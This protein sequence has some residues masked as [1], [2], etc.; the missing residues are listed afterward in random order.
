[1]LKIKFE[2]GQGLGNQLWNYC[3]IRSIANKLSQ[4]FC[5]DGYENFHGKNFL[6]IDLGEPAV[7]LEFTLFN[8]RIYYDIDLEYFSSGYDERVLNIAENMCLKGLFQDERYFY[9]NHSI[10]N[11]YLKY[12]GNEYISDRNICVLNIR[13]GEYK[14]YKNFNL[15]K[16]YWLNA[17]QH[18][19]D[20]HGVSRFK[21]VTDDKLY[22]N[23]LFNSFEIISDS[24]ER[25]YF[26]LNNANFIISSNS[27]FSYFPIKSSP[28]LKVVIAPAYWARPYNNKNRWCSIGNVYKGWNYMTVNGNLLPREIPYSIR[29][30]TEKFYKMQYSAL[31]SADYLIKRSWYYFLPKKI[32]ILFNKI[33]KR[34]APNYLG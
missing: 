2:S 3:S 16:K 24:I 15:E 30:E 7:D 32:K 14:R 31:T 6:K 28:L 10:P 8:E 11:E 13:G 12:I 9:D 26:E 33:F 21:I 25:C 19:Q 1:M 23:N 29:D 34:L 5:V 4:K 27:T 18:M 17:M 20:L 22:A